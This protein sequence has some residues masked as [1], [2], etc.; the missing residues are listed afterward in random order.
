MPKAVEKQLGEKARGTAAP[1]D[2]N[3]AGNTNVQMWALLQ[4]ALKDERATAK[5]APIRQVPSQAEEDPVGDV[6]LESC[7]VG[8]DDYANEMYASDEDSDEDLFGTF[9][10]VDN[11]DVKHE[12]PWGRSVEMTY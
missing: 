11:H 9:S 3:V 10:Q 4:K 8:E 2:R 7:V 12:T 6:L 1:L 5:L